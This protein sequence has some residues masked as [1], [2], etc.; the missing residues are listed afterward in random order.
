MYVSADFMVN[1]TIH[2]IPSSKNATLLIPCIRC[3]RAFTHPYTINHKPYTMY[4]S[5][6]TSVQLFNIHTIHHTA[7]THPFMHLFIYSSIYP[8]KTYI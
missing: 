1:I 5:P 8:P 4:H 3:K 2:L 6:F 7:F